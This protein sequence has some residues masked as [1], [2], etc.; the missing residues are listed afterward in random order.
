MNRWE[1]HGIKIMKNF[2]QS[3]HK[4][5]HYQ[6][7]WNMWVCPWV[8]VFLLVFETQIIMRKCQISTNFTER[9]KRKRKKTREAKERIRQQNQSKTDTHISCLEYLKLDRTKMKY[10]EF[11]TLIKASNKYTHNNSNH[12]MIP[13]S[14]V[15]LDAMCGR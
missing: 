9:G 7:N 4:H 3:K 13:W 12:C 2:Y 5:E 11:R 14:W 10:Q 15:Q 1:F 8:H 6:L